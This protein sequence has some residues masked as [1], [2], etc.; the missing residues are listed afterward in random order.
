[1]N[2]EM[3]SALMAEA[4]AMSGVPTLKVPFEVGV[5]EAA[6]VAKRRGKTD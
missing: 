1:M 3:K 5:R 4:E 6:L 2:E